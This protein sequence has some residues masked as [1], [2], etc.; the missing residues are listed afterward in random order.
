MYCH[1]RL[2]RFKGIQVQTDELTKSAECPS[3]PLILTNAFPNIERAVLRI[4]RRRSWP[5]RAVQTQVMTLDREAKR[6]GVGLALAKNN[7]RDC[8]IEMLKQ[9]E[10][11]K[12]SVAGSTAHMNWRTASLLIGLRY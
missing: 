2:K 11:A 6:N 12:Q 9:Q 3:H 5:R 8:A 7:W 10:S 4:P 1:R